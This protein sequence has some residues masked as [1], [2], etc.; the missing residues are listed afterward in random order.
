MTY[1][2]GTECVDMYNVDIEFKEIGVKG[3]TGFVY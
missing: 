3:L 2:R 1:T